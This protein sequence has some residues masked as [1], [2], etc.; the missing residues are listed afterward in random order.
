MPL[1]TCAC[2]VA[3]T[4]VP[5]QLNIPVTLILMS[6][7]ETQF[8]RIPPPPPHPTVYL[9]RVIQR[10]VVRKCSTDYTNRKTSV[11]DIFL[12]KEYNKHSNM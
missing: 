12:V 11:K 2:R 3:F 5:Y 9:T 10:E 6:C 8:S 4:P 1:A 7:I